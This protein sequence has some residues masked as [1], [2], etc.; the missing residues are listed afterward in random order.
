MIVKGVIDATRSL[1]TVPAK[2]LYFLLDLIKSTIS[3]KKKKYAH[4]WKTFWE[5]QWS[6]FVFH[7]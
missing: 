6:S 2:R 3:Q 4:R 5:P 1:K 7:V